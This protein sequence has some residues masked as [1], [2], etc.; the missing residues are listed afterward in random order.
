MDEQWQEIY[1]GL[2]YELVLLNPGAGADRGPIQ[3]ESCF[4]CCLRNWEACKTMVRETGFDN[5]DA[6]I[7]F[8]RLFKPRFTGQLEYYSLVYQYQL[9]HPHAPGDLAAFRRRERD[10]IDRFH[11]AHAAFIAYCNGGYAYDDHRYF[12]RRNFDPGELT[13][14]RPFDRDPEFRT[15]GDWTLTLLTGNDLY[16]H[17]LTR[18]EGRATTEEKRQTG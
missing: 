1:N 3:T 11:I 17:F 10:K 14:V 6:E 18:E 5:D 13:Y 15:A 12:L 7:R 4:K 16:E 8:F 2:M 9:F